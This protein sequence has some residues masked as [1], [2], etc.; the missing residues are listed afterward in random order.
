MAGLL[1][2]G[3]SGLAAFQRAL[4]TIGHNVSNSNTEGYSRQRVEFGTR[5]P[6]L[7]GAGWV[8]T[9]VQATNIVRIY[10]DFVAGQMRAT[11]S[12]ASEMKALFENASR[13]D[14]ILAD[15]EVGMDPVIQSFFDS[16]Q[17]LS[18]DPSSAS[19]R[20]LVLAEAASMTDRFSYFDAQYDQLRREVNQKLEESI[21]SVNTIASNIANINQAIVYALGGSDQQPPNDLLDQREQLVNELSE[22]VEVQTFTQANG[23]MNVLI[24]TGQPLVIGTDAS[25]LAV[26]A[27]PEDAG[28]PEISVQTTYSN[29]IITEQLTGGE[30][31]GLLV[32]REQFLNQGQN[33]LGLVAAGLIESINYQ[34]RL[35][36]DLLGQMGGDFFTPIN[37]QAEPSLN[38]SGSAAV[39]L[40]LSATDLADL[41]GSDYHLEFNGGTSY[42]LTRLSDNTTTSIDTSLPIPVID[43][44]QLTIGAGS[45]AGD[46]FMI[47]PTRNVAGNISVLI[48]DTN[49]IAAAGPLRSAELTDANGNPLNTGDVVLSDLMVNSATGLPY[50]VTMSLQFTN[51]ADGLGNPGFTITNGPGAPN[52]FILY[53]PSTDYLAGRSYPDIGNPT[54]FDAFGGISFEIRG[55]PAVGDTFIIENN[56][57][58]TADN[59]NIIEIAAIQNEL[60][61][62]GGTTTIQGTY[63]QLV[64]DVGARTRQAEANF[65]SQEGLLSVQKGELSSISGVNLDEE[66]ANL[67]RFQ[68]AYQAAAQV[69][70]VANT[71]FDTLL[72]AVRR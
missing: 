5:E 10:D 55:T 37:V 35:G 14:N 56:T 28:S 50:G 25:T 22:L 13:L 1:G 26:T 18:D 3:T 39:N 51:D 58:G 46:T 70:A 72:G 47:R 6:F 29:Q 44:F 9:G 65:Q 62:K 36:Q 71:L 21:H 15:Q 24:G 40:T 17:V 31:G 67:A 60:T 8:G 52:D 34:H 49:R 57:G 43:G 68:Q 16:L 23:A 4:T 7:T 12:V 19:A 59:R 30:I 32:F 27:D 69:V 42:T 20:Q 45:V 66:A 11:Q 38:N 33:Q 61:M 48:E 2:I 41:T 54:Q 64:S 63:A 53:D